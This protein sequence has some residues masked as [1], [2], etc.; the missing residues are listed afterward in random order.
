MKTREECLLHEK[1]SEVSEYLYIRDN[2]QESYI[3]FLHYIDY[4]HKWR[5]Q[6]RLP[7]HFCRSLQDGRNVR[8]GYERLRIQKVPSVSL[9]KNPGVFH[10]EQFIQGPRVFDGFPRLVGDKCVNFVASKNCLY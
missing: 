6:G 7:V 1:W 2:L 9:E 10:C 4:M 8:N 5:L 3:Y